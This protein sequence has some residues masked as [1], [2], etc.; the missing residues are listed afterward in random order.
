MKQLGCAHTEKYKGIFTLPLWFDLMTTL[1]FL[2][3]NC[4]GNQILLVLVKKFYYLIIE[5]LGGSPVGAEFLI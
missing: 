2:K 1:I 5:A 4:Q 3:K